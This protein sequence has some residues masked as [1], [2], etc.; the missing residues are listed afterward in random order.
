[1]R[2]RHLRAMLRSGVVTPEQLEAAVSGFAQA[3]CSFIWLA[4]IDGAVLEKA[5]RVFLA[6][7]GRAPV[8][9]VDFHLNGDYHKICRSLQHDLHHYDAYLQ[10]FSR[11]EQP[12]VPVPAEES[13]G[14]INR[15]E[16][17]PAEEPIVQALAE[18]PRQARR[19]EL[20]KKP[21][22]PFVMVVVLGFCSIPILAM[23]L[24]TYS[25]GQSLAVGFIMGIL[26]LMILLGALVLTFP[27]QAR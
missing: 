23:M 2:D 26:W 15:A 27:R 19:G 3:P 25:A 22:W 8:E 10:E 17:P 24:A 1:M 4:A 14:Q 12:P 9:N 11:T 13:T 16:P 21:I 6:K 7:Q 20:K 5:D 18:E